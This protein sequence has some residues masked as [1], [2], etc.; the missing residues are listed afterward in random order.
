MYIGGEQK[1]FIY[2]IKWNVIQFI[3]F[4]FFMKHG[5]NTMTVPLPFKE[6]P[7]S[8]QYMSVFKTKSY[9]N[10]KS[11]L[12]LIFCTSHCFLLHKRVILTHNRYSPCYHDVTIYMAY[13]NQ[14]SH[15]SGQIS[16]VTCFFY[17]R[18]YI[19]LKVI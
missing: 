15:L 7:Y 5:C 12:K 14:K 9:L 17:C 13:I 11:Y 1:Y 10:L 3:K 2:N 4:T 16:M 6:A 8:F 19:V 18:K